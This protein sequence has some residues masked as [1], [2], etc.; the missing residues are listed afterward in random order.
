MPLQLRA[1]SM[2]AAPIHERETP[3]PRFALE[4]A[5][6]LALPRLATAEDLATQ[7]LAARARVQVG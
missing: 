3:E 1:S 5:Q 4:K 2:L 7:L 6:Q